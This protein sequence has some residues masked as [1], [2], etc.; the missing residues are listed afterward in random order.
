[1]HTFVRHCMRFINSFRA[2]D[3]QLGLKAGLH[4][5]TWYPVQS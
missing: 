3:N 1:M 4:V 2:Y 5:Y